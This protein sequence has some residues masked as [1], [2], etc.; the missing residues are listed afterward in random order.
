MRYQAARSQAQKSV[1]ATAAQQTV[2]FILQ[3]KGFTLWAASSLLSGVVGLSGIFDN[4]YVTHGAVGLFMGTQAAAYVASEKNKQIAYLEKII[5]K[6]SHQIR[7]GSK[8][9][10]HRTHRPAKPKG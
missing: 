4:P 5:E 7:C 9:A 1:P 10:C 6:R 3:N 8:A 2:L